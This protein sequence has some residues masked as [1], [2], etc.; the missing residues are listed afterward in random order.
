MLCG[1]CAGMLARIRQCVIHFLY[2]FDCLLLSTTAIGVSASWKVTR[3][4]GDTGMSQT[5]ADDKRVS[6]PVGSSPDEVVSTTANLSQHAEQQS[7]ARERGGMWTSSGRA[8]PTIVVLL[9]LIGLGY[10]GHSTDWKMP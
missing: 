2:C 10:W 9:A 8:I 4:D 7:A 6:N 3:H 1:S 5:I